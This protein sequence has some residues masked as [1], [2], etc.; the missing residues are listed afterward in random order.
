MVKDQSEQS[1][2]SG[3]SAYHFPNRFL[4]VMVF[5]YRTCDSL[6]VLR[7][8]IKALTAFATLGITYQDILNLEYNA[9]LHWKLLPLHS[10]TGKGHVII[11]RQLQQ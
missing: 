9:C 2:Q 3:I 1:L 5:F 8:T 7:L 6:M 11:H 4:R 10:E